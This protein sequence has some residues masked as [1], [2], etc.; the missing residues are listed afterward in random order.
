[1]NK[2]ATAAK[3]PPKVD[4]TLARNLGANVYRARV[5]LTPFPSRQALE[6]ASGVSEETIRKI[7]D[8]RDPS[9]PAHF[10]ELEKVARLAAGLRRLGAT[11]SAPELFATP[12][13]PTGPPRHLSV[14]PGTGDALPR[15]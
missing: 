8:S 2:Q 15:R 5:M 10:P 11:I 9:K 14:V 13:K 7:E 4:E 12:S 6:A 1:M 3:R